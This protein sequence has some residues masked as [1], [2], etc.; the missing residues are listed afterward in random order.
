MKKSI[1]TLLF[2]SIMTALIAQAQSYDI[3]IRGG[4]LIDPRN[5]INEPMD[6]AVKDGKIA[7]IAKKIDPAG[8]VQVVNAKGFYVT[9]GL[10]DMHVHVYQG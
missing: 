5:N 4:H 3:V 8:A 2:M 1:F 6:I 7:M 10:I 9:P